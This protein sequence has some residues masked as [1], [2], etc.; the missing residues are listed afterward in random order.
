MVKIFIPFND[1]S[2]NKLHRGIKTATCRSKP[3]GEVNDTFE[4][5]LENRPRGQRVVSY[6]V[7]SITK[8]SLKDVSK[9][10]FAEEGAKSP[11]EFIEVWNDIHPHRG[12]QPEDIRFFIKFKEVQ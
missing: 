10:H 4:V 6:I 3:Y 9:N 12:F 1:W 11:E 5:F 7:A 8:K 2:K